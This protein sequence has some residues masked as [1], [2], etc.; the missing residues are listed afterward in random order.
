MQQSIIAILSGHEQATRCADALKKAGFTSDEISIL[1][2]DDFGAQELGFTR[3]TKVFEGLSIGV[4]AGAVLGIGFALVAS[5]TDLSQGSMQAFFAAGPLVSTLALAAIFALALGA[6]G[7][8]IGLSLSEFIIH[9]YD[10]K[11]RFSSSL[12]AVHADNPNEARIVQNLLKLEGAQEI[13]KAEEETAQ[14][15]RE[16]LAMR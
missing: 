7:G 2:P 1:L 4:I 10:R 3:K 5:Q 11:T 16:Q 15:R 8:L 13:T 6:L 12:M 14:N 9:K